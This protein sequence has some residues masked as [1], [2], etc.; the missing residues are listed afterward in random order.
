MISFLIST[1]I[2]LLKLINNSTVTTS[3]EL[4]NSDRIYSIITLSA[5][6]SPFVYI[7]DK[8]VN[9]TISN[10]SYILIVLGAI[11]IDWVFGTWKHIFIKKDFILGKNAIGLV[12]KLTLAVAGGF[13]FEG[14][15]YLVSGS[16]LLVEGSKII[17][18]IIV[19]TYPALSAFE[20]IYIA[21]GERFPP[22]AWMDRLIKW[23]ESLD[24]RDLYDN[25][26]NNKESEN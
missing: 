23:H 13:L 2:N 10:E 14:L 6:I 12:T 11:L 8:L 20:N 22:K 3:T 7:A 26:D 5:V 4:I 9:W 15:N 1:V 25:K 16:D 21:S 24:P 17:T 18:R 19:F